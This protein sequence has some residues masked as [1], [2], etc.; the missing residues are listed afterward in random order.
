MQM[1][2]VHLAEAG[3]HA[4]DLGEQVGGERRQRDEA[5]LD[6]DALFAER[7]EQIGAGVGIDHGLQ[8]DLR[9]AELGAGQ[10]FAV[11]GAAGDAEE[12][13]DHRHRRIEV[14][15][16]LGRVAGGAGE[17]WRRRRGLGAGGAAA[18]PRRPPR[19]E[20]RSRS[21]ARSVDDRA[22]PG[23]PRTGGAD[24]R[25]RRAAR[26]SDRPASALRAAK[27]GVELRTK[28][29][30]RMKR[31]AARHACLLTARRPR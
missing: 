18:A 20:R 13:A 17:R 9:L 14:V 29:E 31:E 24:R 5:L 25:A 1:E 23:A 4:A 27:G 30:K 19:V 28:R 16:R 10:I 3:A 11:A 15:R 6:L 7:E 12:V 8:R 21:R 2:R 22:R 26:R